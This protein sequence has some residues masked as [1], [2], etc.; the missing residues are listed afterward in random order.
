[1][2]EDIIHLILSEINYF[3]LLINSIEIIIEKW[4][5]GISK[6]KYNIVLNISINH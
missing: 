3:L 5:F 2:N 1:M 4:K 6:I